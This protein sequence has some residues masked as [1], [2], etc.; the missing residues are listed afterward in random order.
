LGGVRAADPEVKPASVALQAVGGL[1]ARSS[2]KLLSPNSGGDDST[3][4]LSG[5]ENLDWMKGSGNERK[6]KKIASAT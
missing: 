5:Q 3:V 2:G 4:G 1:D 6:A